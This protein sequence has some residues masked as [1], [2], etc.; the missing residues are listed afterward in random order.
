M[1]FGLMMNDNHL[2]NLCA[3]EK[4]P[5]VQEYLSSDATDE[6]KKRDVMLTDDYDWTAL[7]WMCCHSASY[8]VMKMMVDLVMA[9][10]QFGSTALKYL[11]YHINTYNVSAYSLSSLSYLTIRVVV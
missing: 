10:H 2:Y 7:H 8:D 6:E 4:W 5:E 9:R 11:C 1:Y 3:N